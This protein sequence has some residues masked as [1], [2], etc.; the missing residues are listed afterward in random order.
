MRVGVA[1]LL[2]GLVLSL[3]VLVGVGALGSGTAQAVD[4]T[5]PAAVSS[6]VAKGGSGSVAL[7]WTNPTT[8]DLAGVLLVRKTGTVAPVSATDGTQV[9]RVLKPA[10]T[11]T[12]RLL[13]AATSYAYAAFAYDTSGNLARPA[14]AVATTALT[15]PAVVRLDGTLAAD[16]TLTPKKAKLFL[17]DG[18]FTVPPGRVLTLG[19]GAKVKVRYDLDVAGTLRSTGTSTSRALVTSVY[20]D[21][22]GGDAANTIGL[23]KDNPFRV[24][25]QAGGVVQLAGADL[26]FG[27]LTNS[28][29]TSGS[30]GS[31]TVRT[32]AIRNSKVELNFFG[33]GASAATFTGNTFTRSSVYL[34]NIA[35]PVLS[36]NTFADGAGFGSGLV[37]ASP[38]YLTVI[39]DLAGIGANTATGTAAQQL[40]VIVNSSVRTLDPAA[41]LRVRPVRHHRPQRRGR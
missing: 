18:T 31:F 1:S 38:V 40:F 26:R 22:V 8:A 30:L 13:D 10:R 16:V 19:A 15:P 34:A 35:A 9:A 36:G 2:R 7:S 11:Y 6:F 39:G 41:R 12:D 27:R 37:P 5:P 23:A 32:S 14:K 24:D 29:L 3:L 28:S 20:D 21:T 33:G 17:V 25:L 4:T